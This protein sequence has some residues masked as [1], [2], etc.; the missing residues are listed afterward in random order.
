[1]SPLDHDPEGLV[2]AFKKSG[3]TQRAF[4]Q[5]IGKSPSMVS[6]MFK[7]TRNMTP[8]TLLAAAKV[9]NCPV[10]VLERKRAA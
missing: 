7:G 4:A 3:L 8:A 9:L 1:M 2:W 10:T 5:A 6:E